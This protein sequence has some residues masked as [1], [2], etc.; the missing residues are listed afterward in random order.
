MGVM[1]ECTRSNQQGFRIRKECIDFRTNS[2]NCNGV[3][4]RY[5]G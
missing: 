5:C 3:L 2:V 1:I 4:D